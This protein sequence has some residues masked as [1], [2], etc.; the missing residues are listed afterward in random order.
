M[1]N[2]HLAQA[3]SEESLFALLQTL[4]NQ[5]INEKQELLKIWGLTTLQYDSLYVL[6][7][8]DS[9][10]EGISNTEIGDNLT[11]RVPDI[12]RLL[13]RMAEKNWV[14]RNRDEKNRRV[15]RTSLTEDGVAL[16]K[17]AMPDILQLSKKQFANLNNDEKNALKSI[18]NKAIHTK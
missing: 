14:I 5:C 1:P 4:N 13:D 9:K 18:L 16:V 11:T 8:F 6:Y 2:N 7:V 12:T 17:S 10:R 3:N 15:M